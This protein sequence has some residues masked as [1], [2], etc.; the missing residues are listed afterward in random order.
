MICQTDFTIERNAAIMIIEFNKTGFSPMRKNRNPYLRSKNAI[1]KITKKITK[2]PIRNN[3]DLF[4]IFSP[5]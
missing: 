3:N 4:L 2:N 1:V 5:P